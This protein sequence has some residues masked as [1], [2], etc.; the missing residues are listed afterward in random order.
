LVRQLAG[1]SAEEAGA[2]AAADAVPAGAAGHAG[3]GRR[4][5]D[6]VVEGADPVGETD[7]DRPATG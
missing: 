3:G 6:G 7:L 4:Q 1:E 2:E 5:L